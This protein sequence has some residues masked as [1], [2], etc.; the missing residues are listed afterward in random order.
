MKCI[1]STGKISILCL[2]VQFV[3][4]TSSSWELILSLLEAKLHQNEEKKKSKIL[5]S[6]F[7]GAP[8]KGGRPPPI[9]LQL[10]LRKTVLQGKEKDAWHFINVT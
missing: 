3:S 4:G 5:Q 1:I 8:Q 6:F 10:A 2:H 7:F 9:H